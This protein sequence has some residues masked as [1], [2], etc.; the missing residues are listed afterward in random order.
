M[1]NILKKHKNAQDGIHVEKVEPK[2]ETVTKR[3]KKQTKARRGLEQSASSSTAVQ[4]DEER[5]HVQAYYG[6]EFNRELSESL[7]RRHDML[8]NDLLAENNQYAEREPGP[9]GAEAPEYFQ[10]I[11]DHDGVESF[12]ALHESDQR[13][14]A[15][16]AGS[17]EEFED[18][19]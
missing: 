14:D 13:E 10:L 4:L 17:D 6:F 7:I 12:V 16:N 5:E 1:K 19:S 11:A 2:P 18:C 15:A 3:V 8:K 9:S